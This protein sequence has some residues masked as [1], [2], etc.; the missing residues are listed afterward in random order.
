MSGTEGPIRIGD[1]E[2]EEAVT[3]L[4]KHY[5][6]GRLSAEEHQER[7]GDA[8]QAKTAAD[9]AA[10][11]A[12]L[13]GAGFSG[14]PGA[15]GAG[16]SGSSG[17]EQGW[18]GPW[19][20]AKPPWS[21]PQDSAEAGAGGQAAYGQGPG[22][23]PWGPGR[24]GAR[25]PWGS[26]AGGPGAR[27][28]WGAGRPPYGPGFFGRIPLPVLIALAVV[29]VLASIG[30]VVAGGHPPFLPLLLIVAGVFIVKKRT[31]ERRA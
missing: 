5:E 11:F 7:V 6:A 20:W 31:Q 14:T 27:G 16:A 2:R 19:G 13:P 1:Q 24:P 9:L 4:D 10:L 25:G 29:G 28:P 8:L 18:A 26:G 21:A 30:C 3:Q 12:D 17:E 15:G 23:Q 22:E